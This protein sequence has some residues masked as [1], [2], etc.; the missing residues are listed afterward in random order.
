MDDIKQI[1]NL[2][3]DDIYELPREKLNMYFI[4]LSDQ[5]KKKLCGKIKN[6]KNKLIN[7]MSTINNVKRGMFTPFP[8]EPT[9]NINGGSKKTKTKRKTT[10]KTRKPKVHTGPRGGKYIM[11]KGKKVYV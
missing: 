8:N 5:Y 4:I 10:K 7:A 11:R 2:S 6:K 3:N 9:G 1:L